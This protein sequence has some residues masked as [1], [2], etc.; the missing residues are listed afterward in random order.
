MMDRVQTLEPWNVAE[1]GW[2]QKLGSGTRSSHLLNINPRG[3][4]FGRGTVG[5]I[6]SKGDEGQLQSVRHGDTV[7]K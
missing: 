2:G 6:C 4:L 7:E 5:L 3:C 1:S